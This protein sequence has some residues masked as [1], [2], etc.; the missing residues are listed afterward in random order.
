MH[1]PSTEPHRS[2]SRVALPGRRPAAVP[3]GFTLIEMLV[4]V[5]VLGVMA[6]IAAPQLSGPLAE[7]RVRA[8]SAEFVASLGSARTEAARRGVPVTLCPRAAAS[9]TCATG[10]ADWNQGWVL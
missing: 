9:N 6:A 1:H 2:A 7:T 4:S 5:T 8:M 10:A 3:A